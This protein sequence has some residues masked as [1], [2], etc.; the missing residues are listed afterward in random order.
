MILED[1]D[2]M[3]QHSKAADSDDRELEYVAHPSRY[4]RLMST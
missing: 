2:A 3:S 1:D 4:T